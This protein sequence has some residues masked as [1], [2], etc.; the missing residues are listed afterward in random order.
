MKQKIFI[1]VAW[2]YVNGNLHIGHAA[3][4]LLP[5]DI[6]ARFARLA[7]REVL[8]VSGSDCFGTPITIQADREK[9][10]P[11]AIVDKYHP[12]N[13]DLFKKM[14]LSFDIYTKTTTDNHR[15]IVQ[16][17]L[18]TFWK[19]NLLPILKQPQY[20]DEAESRFLPDRYIEGICPECKAEESKSDQ[21]EA[22]GRLHNQDLINPK[23]KLTGNQVVL[24]ETEHLFIAWDKLEG[25]IKKYFESSSRG[26]RQ[27]VGRET[28][29]WLERGLKP[30]A[31]TRDL[32]WGIEIPSE[33]AKNLKNADQKR[34]YVWFEAV[35]G[36]L[37]ASIEW[38]QKTGGDWK[39]F[40]QSKNCG[41]YYFM[42][43]DN[44]VFHT[45]FW[46]GE[47][48]VFN[49]KLNLPDF[50]M[51]NQFLNFEG[52]K[53]SKSRGLIVDTAQFIDRFGL[54]AMRFYITSIMP[55]TTD[56][57]F[58]WNDFLTKNNDLLV[59][60]IG[61]FINRSL[62]VY[63]ELATVDPVISK[64]VTGQLKSSFQAAFDHLSNCRFKDYIED[65]LVIARFANQ[66]IDQLEP[67][68]LKKADPKKFQ[69][70]AGNMLALA[71]GLSLLLLPVTVEASSRFFEITGSK[72]P[73]LWPAVEKLESFL[74][75]FLSTIKF[76]KITPLF[77]KFKQED[78]EQFS[79]S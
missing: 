13:I 66:K 21:C 63:G 12:R 32:D 64:E 3:G 73:T 15:Q 47:L 70:S 53:F 33:I 4:Y 65:I 68:K 61:N 35:I 49:E 42:G 16:Q 58:A 59:A 74:I 37:S 29:G 62:V 54:D 20:Y 75:D 69:K 39:D 60:Q 22:C 50:P 27:W 8:M 1:G 19:K 24:K 18:L 76:Q 6:F 23:S 77:R 26:W 48:M 28:A 67:W 52:Q 40:W 46:P 57:S 38:S 10:T 34:I 17:F 71:A 55:E 11:A 30:R 72:T 44:L 5:A 2:P 9:T 79:E 36:Y 78:I 14:A 41:H 56:S 43:K 45:I 51:I 25:Q 7:G 31:V